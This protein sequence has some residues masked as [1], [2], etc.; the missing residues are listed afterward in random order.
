[1][2]PGRQAALC[3]Q[4]WICTLD[5]LCLGLL[6][7][8]EEDRGVLAWDSKKTLSTFPTQGRCGHCARDTKLGSGPSVS[9]PCRQY[10]K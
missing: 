7:T 8:L 9:L 1:M 2:Q 6:F 5:E 3:V 10:Q 4:E